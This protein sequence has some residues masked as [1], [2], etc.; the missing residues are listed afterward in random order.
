[1]QQPKIPVASEGVPFI[2]FSGFATLVFALVGWTLPVLLCL[3]LTAFVL[4]FFRDPIRV[5]PADPGAII[6]PADGKVIQVREVDDHR[7]SQQRLMKIS[8]FMNV[9]NVHVNRVPMTGTV[10]R[11]ILSPGA[12]YAADKDKAELHNEY[13]ALT[14][15]TP[16][17]LQYTVV[18]L[19][20]LIARRIVCWAEQ[21]DQVAGGQKFGLIRFGSRVDLYLPLTAQIRVRTGEKVRAGETI[22]G[23]VAEGQGQEKT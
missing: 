17:G 9:F 15:T 4:Y 21:G 6:S 19:A 3:L 8:I 22:L 11:V 13:C 10:N 7:F 20:G 18:Q 23:F 16:A 1:M 2:L 5:V 12:F 14:I